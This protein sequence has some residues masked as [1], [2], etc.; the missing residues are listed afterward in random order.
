MTVG[1]KPSPGELLQSRKL[2]TILFSISDLHPT[3]RLSD[4]HSSLGKTI[5]GMMLMLR[6][7]SSSCP[8]S[9]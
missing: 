8:L 7:S 5:T 3:V 1:R 2:K 9:L 4:P 6:I